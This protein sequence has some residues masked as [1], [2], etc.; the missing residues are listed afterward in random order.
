VFNR[1]KVGDGSPEGGKSFILRGED[2]ALYSAKR[3]G[4][5]MRR[6]ASKGGVIHTSIGKKARVEGRRKGK[7]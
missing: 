4:T 7:M 3:G 1:E 2:C 6:R 5:E